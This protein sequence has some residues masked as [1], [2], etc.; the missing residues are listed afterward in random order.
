MVV[1]QVFVMTSVGSF[2]G[3]ARLLVTV[4]NAVATSGGH[5]RWEYS[6]QA[7]LRAPPEA[8]RTAGP[9]CMQRA[10]EVA[11]PCPGGTLALRAKRRILGGQWTAL[12]GRRMYT[13]QPN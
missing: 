4:F 8:K 10:V 11:L 1:L 5:C 6:V 12:M 2:G 3:A 7:Q 9:L 13:E